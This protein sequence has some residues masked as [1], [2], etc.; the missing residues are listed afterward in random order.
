MA[1]LLSLP[2]TPFFKTFL[3]PL[4]VLLFPQFLLHSNPLSISLP[5]PF[6][7]IS[8][9]LLLCLYYFLLCLRLLTLSPHYYLTHYILHPLSTKNFA[10]PWLSSIRISCPSISSSLLI[11]LSA[12]DSV[13]L[14]SLPLLLPLLNHQIYSFSLLSLF[15]ISLLFF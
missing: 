8:L 6:D 2:F 14:L 11:S 4:S 1:F 10:M 13:S 7:A 5:L 3:L 15:F 9:L 12:F